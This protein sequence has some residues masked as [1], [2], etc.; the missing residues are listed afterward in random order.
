LPRV[1]LSPAS[2]IEHYGLRLKAVEGQDDEDADAERKAAQGEIQAVEEAFDAL[3]T[4]HNDV[5]KN[6][7]SH[8]PRCWH[9][10]T[11]RTTLSS[12]STGPKFKGNVIDLGT[13]IPVCEFIMKMLNAYPPNRLDAAPR[14]HLRQETHQNDDGDQGWQSH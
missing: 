9:P 8:P 6:Y 2:V 13:N 11:R 10:S 12:R 14:Y 3:H 7:P 1:L 5:D 4:F